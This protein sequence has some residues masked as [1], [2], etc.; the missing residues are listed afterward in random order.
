MTGGGQRPEVRARGSNGET[1][2]PIRCNPYNGPYSNFLAR[3]SPAYGLKTRSACLGPAD[4]VEQHH[5]GIRC[6][7][8]RRGH[9]DDRPASG[10]QRRRSKT[11]P[12]RCPIAA[13]VDASG[14]AALHSSWNWEPSPT[15]RSTGG[16][17]ASRIKNAHPA[18][19]RSPIMTSSGSD[20]ELRHWREL[21][22]AC[23]N[24]GADALELNLSC[25]H[26]DRKDMG[27][28]RQRSAAV[29]RHAGRRKSRASRSRPSSRRRRPTS[30]SKRRRSSQAP[31]RSPRQYVPVAAARRSRRSSSR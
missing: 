19:S 22:Q 26:M 2:A 13:S 30:P 18:R 9:Q 10:G 4:R 12:A 1:R 31:M 28:H 29:R 24:E 14:H 6:G 5:A 11:K 3:R 8:G 16:C 25:P 7:L 27:Q 21:A 23:Q 15:R 20:D 17:P